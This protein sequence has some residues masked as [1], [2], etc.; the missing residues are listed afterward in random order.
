MA[1]G[2]ISKDSNFAVDAAKKAVGPDNLE[3][4]ETTMKGLGRLVE[5]IH[6]GCSQLETGFV[7]G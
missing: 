7:A 3:Q 1:M 2:R 6:R 5:R 4:T